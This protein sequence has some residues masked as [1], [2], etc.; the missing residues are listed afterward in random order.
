ML[1]HI[2]WGEVRNMWKR[3]KEER[4]KIGRPFSVSVSQVVQ[5]WEGRDRNIHDD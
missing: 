1:S 3:D 5:F 2:A 4:L